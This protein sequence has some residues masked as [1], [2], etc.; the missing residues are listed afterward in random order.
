M[1]VLVGAHDKHKS[2][3][4]SEGE[5]V[6]ACNESMKVDDQCAISTDIDDKDNSKDDDEETFL[7]YIDLMLHCHDEEVFYE[8]ERKCREIAKRAKNERTIVSHLD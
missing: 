7:G 5:D 6:A 2:T 8:T 4:D 3:I 1:Y